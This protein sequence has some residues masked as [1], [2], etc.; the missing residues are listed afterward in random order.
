MASNPSAFTATPATIGAAPAAAVSWQPSDNALLACSTGD[1]ALLTSTAILTA[2]TLYLAK[3]PIRSAVTITNLVF[4]VATVAAGAS[5]G[6]FAGLYSSAGAL[7]SGSA[8]VNAAF[9]AQ[10]PATCAL[11][12]PQALAAGGFVWAALL[13]NFATTQ[14]TLLKGSTATGNVPNVGLAAAVYRFA[15]NGTG[16]V[17][18][19]GSITPA[20]NSASGLL[21]LWCGGN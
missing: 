6:T 12:A 10:G 8:D 15:V 9:L 7:L 18:L 13:A 1:P 19:P 14:P 2:G 3:L 5:T 20:S 17:A 4:E 16:L 11:S 21:T